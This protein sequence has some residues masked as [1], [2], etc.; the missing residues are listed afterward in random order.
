MLKRC[1]KCK[2]EK[3]LDC[4]AKDKYAKDSLTYSCRECRN[5]KTNEW[6]KA[7]KEIQYVKNLQWRKDNPE[8][9][10]KLKKK[11]YEKHKGKRIATNK[12][13]VKNNSEEVR[14]KYK[15][16]QRKKERTDLNYKLRRRLR[17]RLYI[18]IK[19]KQKVGSAI[20]DLGCSIPEFKEYLQSKFKEGMT[21]NNHSRYGWHIDHIKPLDSF[22]LT[23][24]T[25]L[26]E[27]IHYSNLQPLWATENLQKAAKL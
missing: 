26:L 1:S 6:N 4:F 23:D 10:A 11:D 24:R 21:W 14:I 22:D 27:A 16:W 12:K 19:N 13:W 3:S 25:Q 17:T 7:H 9:W 8:R 18:A 15:Y 20:S 2:I 5:I